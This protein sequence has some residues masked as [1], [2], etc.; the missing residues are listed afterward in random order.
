MNN[1]FYEIEQN[2]KPYLREDERE[3]NCNNSYTRERENV[4]I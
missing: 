3:V 4:N 2:E 1:G